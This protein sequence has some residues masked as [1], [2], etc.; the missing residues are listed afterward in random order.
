M[1]AE[2][3]TSGKSSRLD[4]VGTDLSLTDTFMPLFDSRPVLW[5]NIAELMHRKYGKE[6]LSQLAKE[7]KIGLATIS[8]I[9][10]QDTSVGLE[11]IDRIATVMGVEPWQLMHPDFCAVTPSFATYS[12]LAADLAQQLDE[13]EDQSTRERAHALATQVI[14]LAASSTAPKPSSVEQPT[15]PHASGL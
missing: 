8:R 1:Q 12:P 13:I 15:A 5:R 10:N 11:V 2:S 4:S 6:H 7:A 3:S 14:G 9:K